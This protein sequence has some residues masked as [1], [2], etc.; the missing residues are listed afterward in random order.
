[1]P[2]IKILLADDNVFI[3]GHVRRLLEKD[4]D[5]KIVASVSDGAAVVRESSRTK[6]DVIVLDISLAEVS[7]IDV[8]ARLRDSGSIAKI[9]FLTV[10]EDRDFLTAAMGAGGSGRN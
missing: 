2:K 8:A 3:L 9:V 6:P 5:Y 10:H 7:G 4:P 1:M